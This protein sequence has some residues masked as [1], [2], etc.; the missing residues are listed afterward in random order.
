MNLHQLAAAF[1]QIANEVCNATDPKRCWSQILGISGQSS[2]ERL[3]DLDVSADIHAIRRQLG[4]IFNSSPPPQGLAFFYFGLF[5]D[6]SGTGYYLSGYETPD[7]IG[8]LTRGE[9]PSFFPANR[10]LSSHVL[11]AV[12]AETARMPAERK[13]LT[14]AVTFGAGAVVSRFATLGLHLRQ[15]V[16]VGFDSGDFARIK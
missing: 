2:N 6:G 10:H 13:T 11:K 4:E 14:Y 1:R 15:P 3:T 7:A 8:T 9:E 5:D 16:Y 12:D